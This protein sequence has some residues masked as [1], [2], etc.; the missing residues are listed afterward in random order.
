MLILSVP[1]SLVHSSPFKLPGIY[2]IF[3]IVHDYK[4]DL[5]QAMKNPWGKSCLTRP[6]A[7]LLYEVRSGLWRNEVLMS[8]FCHSLH[9]KRKGKSAAL[10]ENLLPDFHL[11]VYCNWECL[12]PATPF[13]AMWASALSWLSE[14]WGSA[15]ICGTLS[16]LRLGRGDTG[17]YWPLTKGAWFQ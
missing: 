5:P 11:P 1:L 8:N 3:Q 13:C 17:P 10:M 4:P 2:I 6:A 12:Q 16:H 14:R 9:I 15:S 7:G